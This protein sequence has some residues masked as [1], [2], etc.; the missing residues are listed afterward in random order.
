VALMLASDVRD[1]AIPS[2]KGTTEDAKLDAWI[3]AF[4][5]LAATWCGWRA[6]DEVTAP[7][8]EK[9]TLALILDG[10]IGGGT[11]LRLGVR[12][13]A[14]FTD[15]REDSEKWAYGTSTIIASTRYTVD[16]A[17][18]WVYATPASGLVFLEGPRVYKANLDVGYTTSS[19]P[20][21]PKSIRHACALQVAHWWM[22]RGAIGRENVSEG[23]KSAAIKALELL[24]EVKA[25]LAEHRIAESWVA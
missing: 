9:T 20:N 17:R 11:I 1:L 7:T 12:P 15:L 10:P 19:T 6:K 21:V 5:S 16:K 18:G 3:A 24:P 8:F 23:G 4:D 14:T 13:I 2:L 25:M 22:N